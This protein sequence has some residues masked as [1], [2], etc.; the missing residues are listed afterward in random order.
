MNCPQCQ[1]PMLDQ[2]ATKQGK[3]PDYT[4]A[5]PGCLNDKGYR[6]GV[7]LKRGPQATAAPRPAPA[8]QPLTE[9]PA[10]LQVP[11]APLPWEATP[12]DE[13]LVKLYWTCF[14]T[15]LAGLKSRKLV[16]LVKGEDVAA[17]T[18]TLY[19]ARSKLL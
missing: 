10:A 3:Q 13:Q 18:A 12:K 11:D 7:W 1:G 6:T 2:R 19:I 15:I 4:C 5:N 17:M 8:P 9:R 14:D 16:E